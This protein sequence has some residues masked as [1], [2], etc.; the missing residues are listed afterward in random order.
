MDKITVIVTIYN[1]L[2]Y[3]RNI[4]LSLLNQTQMIDELIF[5][6]DGSKENVENIIED[7][8]ERCSFSIKKTYQADLNFRAARSRNNGAREAKGDYLIFLDQDMIIPDDF[9]EKIYKARKRK[10]IICTKVISSTEEQKNKIQCEIKKENKVNYTYIYQKY[11]NNTQKVEVVRK[12]KKDMIYRYLY[13]LR[14]RQRG[15]KL[16]GLNFSLYKED[17]IAINGFDEKYV[18]WGE[19]DDDFGNRFFKYGGE[20]ESIK[21]KEYPIHMYHPSAPSKIDLPNLK[22]YQKRKKEISKTNYRA[23]YGYDNILDKDE[24]SVEVIKEKI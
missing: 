23:K 24:I 2:E 4:L 12:I 11:I 1:R 8:I 6:D 9:I 3:A 5:V 15:I 20:V 14:L 22:Y 19:E 16:L 17:Y 13:K 21:F 10:R 18:G 7:L